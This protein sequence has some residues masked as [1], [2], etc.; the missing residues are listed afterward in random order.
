MGILRPCGLRLAFINVIASIVHDNTIIVQESPRILGTRGLS[1]LP[2]GT[3]RCA[4]TGCDGEIASSASGGLAM[5]YYNYR[6]ETFRSC[7]IYQA[8]IA[9]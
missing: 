9:Q 5:T 2:E 6:N 7:L 3:A 4:P 8:G 1:P